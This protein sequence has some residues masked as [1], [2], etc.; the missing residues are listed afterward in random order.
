M[1]DWLWVLDDDDEC[2]Y[3]D[4]VADLRRISAANPS[5]SVVFVR[6]DHGPDLG[7]LPDDETWGGEPVHGH[8]GCSAYIVRRDIWQAHAHA[9]SGGHYASDFDFIKAVWDSHPTV[10]WLDVIAS[11]TQQGRMRG[12]AEDG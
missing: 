3:P 11:R 6:M 4:L 1:G 5:V 10:Y 7:V 2:C 9:F 12:A 8:I